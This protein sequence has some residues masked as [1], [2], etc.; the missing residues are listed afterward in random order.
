MFTICT[1]LAFSRTGFTPP[2]GFW[3][4]WPCDRTAPLGSSRRDLRPFCANVAETS[5]ARDRWP[6]SYDRYP[7]SFPHEY[8]YYLLPWMCPLCW[9]F[10]T[11]N[12][13]KYVNGWFSPLDRAPLDTHPAMMGTK[14]L[15][16]RCSG[17]LRK[18]PKKTKLP[19]KIPPVLVDVPIFEKCQV[20]HRRNCTKPRLVDGKTEKSL[21]KLGNSPSHVWLEARSWWNPM[22]SI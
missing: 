15:A 20:Y 5:G 8:D 3:G 11:K 18:I 16:W 7:Q 13:Q 22:T 9:W 2:G 6:C 21:Q 14:A 17:T 1:N 12:N 4:S 10:H 19:T